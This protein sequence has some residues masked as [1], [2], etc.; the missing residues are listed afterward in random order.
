[1]QTLHLPVKGEYFHQMKSGEKKYE[2]R[3]ANEYWTKRL[4]DRDYD[5]LKIKLGYPKS[6]ELDK[7]ITVPYRGYKMQTITHKH[8]GDKPVDVFA[9][10]VN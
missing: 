6:D 1:M 2:Y 4:V 9:I 10:R 7:I 8:F 5:E 3:L